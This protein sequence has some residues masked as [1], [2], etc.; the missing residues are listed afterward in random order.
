MASKSEIAEIQAVLMAAFP[1][2]RP[3][4][5]VIVSQVWFEILQDLPGD[6]LRMAVLQYCGE[7][8]EFAPSAGTVREYAFRLRA[9][10]AGIPGAYQAYL[11][12]LEMP[13]DQIKSYTGEENGQ[14]VIYHQKVGFSHPLIERVARLLGWPKTF[15][16]DNPAADRAQFL[17]AYE[18]EM[19]RYL[20]D[21]ARLPAVEKYIEET[22]TKALPEVQKLARRL[23]AK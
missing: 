9:K 10:A 18:A 14:F 16:S 19:E 1:N 15:P 4:D 2:Y 12:V 6:L 13:A 8:H 21:A 23:E 5:L 3:A 11:E 17:K 20:E 7:N 22:K